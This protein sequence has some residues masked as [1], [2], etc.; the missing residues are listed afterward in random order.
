MQS[1]SDNGHPDLGATPLA[2]AP[3][4]AFSGLAVV[5]LGAGVLAS[6]VAVGT[7]D[8]LL[9][10]VM[11]LVVTQI[12]WATIWHGVAGVAWRQPLAELRAWPARTLVRPLPYTQPGSAAEKTALA[13][14]HLRDWA[15]ARLLPQYGALLAGLVGAVIVGLVMSLVLGPQPA[16]L[17][18][19][20]VLL[21]QVALLVCRA[22]GQPHAL[23]GGL[24]WVGLPLLMGYALFQ[25]VTLDV[26][27]VAVGL[28][29]AYAGTDSA[30]R[31]RGWWLAGAGV[32]LVLLVATRRPLGAFAIAVLA[33]PQLLLVPSRHIKVWLMAMRLAA[34]IAIS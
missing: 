16:A 26:V 32:V 5:A 23:F 4:L 11:A 28:S 22:N 33:L 30:P 27:L 19:G 20:A 25:S 14:G 29:M 8:S 3:R 10:I 34:A 13:L 18:L 1:A 6:G 21:T 31:A 24:M 9:V 12:G 7:V 17:T 15:N 2:F